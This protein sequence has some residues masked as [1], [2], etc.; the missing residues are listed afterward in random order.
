[1]LPFTF[2]AFAFLCQDSVAKMK[3]RKFVH[4]RNLF[5]SPRFEKK[6][7]QH[8]RHALKELSEAVISC[9]KLLL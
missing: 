9:M 4:F 3:V 8:L 5:L 1:M 2:L 7:D 6:N